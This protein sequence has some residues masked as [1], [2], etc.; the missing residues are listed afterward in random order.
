MPENKVTETTKIYP[1]EVWV[2]VLQVYSD[3]TS[4]ES[5]Y[6][7][8]PMTFLQ[9]NS[10]PCRIDRDADGNVLTIEPIEGAAT[11]VLHGHLVK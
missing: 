4:V 5:N 7:L 3:E 10:R 1:T 11:V 9:F 2:K 6:K 8:D